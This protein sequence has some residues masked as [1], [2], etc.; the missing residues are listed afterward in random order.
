MDIMQWGKDLY[1][2]IEE[3]VSGRFGDG[4][5]SSTYANRR[6]ADRVELDFDSGYKK[7][8]INEVNVVSAGIPSRTT[9]EGDTFPRERN[10]AVATVRTPDEINAEH[11]ANT[12]YP[13]N[14]DMNKPSPYAEELGNRAFASGDRRNGLQQIAGKDE[15]KPNVS[16]SR[17]EGLD[18]QYVLGS[19]V[20][21]STQ[22]TVQPTAPVTEQAPRGALSIDIPAPMSTDGGSGIL[23]QERQG[24]LS[25]FGLQDNWGSDVTDEEW[26]SIPSGA[27]TTVNNII[28]EAQ[29]E[30]KDTNE[31][32]NEA[33]LKGK[34]PSVKGYTGAGTPMRKTD[35]FTFNTITNMVAEIPEKASGIMGFLQKP[36]VQKALL[37]AGVG[38]AAHKAGGFDNTEN[39]LKLLGGAVEGFTARP[40]KANA[41]KMMEAYDEFILD[42][43][44]QQLA[45]YLATDNYAGIADLGVKGMNAMKSAPAER[46]TQLVTDSKS[47]RQVLIDSTTGEEIREITAG[48]E[49]PTESEAAKVVGS[50]EAGYWQWNPATQRYD[51]P[52]AQKGDKGPKMVN[53]RVS[54]EDPV[55]QAQIDADIADMQYVTERYKDISGTFGR[56]AT[57]SDWF[58]SED[59]ERAV[60]IAQKF[61]NRETLAQMEHLKGTPS[62]KDAELVR[63]AA[64]LNR[65]NETQFIRDWSTMQAILE[66]KGGKLSKTELAAR[67]KSINEGKYNFKTEQTKSKV[68]KMY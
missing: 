59:T 39:A 48:R 46:K 7:V 65:D 27:N 50:A 10:T 61:A 12:T 49:T 68:N 18:G 15:F 41:M 64:G 37:L 6:N 47:G 28:E 20:E 25:Q 43:D 33:L 60:A 42:E 19:Y 52:V 9:R 54:L 66:Y 5:A 55:Q 58:R 62:D 13:Y 35:P 24:M 53:G 67:I 32:A 3:G 29:A 34:E 40:D 31:K 63:L 2:T 11:Q 21:P 44:R 16:P 51:I 36:M 4:N 23:G 22:P 45:E 8:P 1:N 17:V 38:Y 26:N 57:T 30:V 14:I 56:S